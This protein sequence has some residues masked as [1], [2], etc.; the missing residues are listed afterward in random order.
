MVINPEDLQMTQKWCWYTWCWPYLAFS[1]ITLKVCWGI[2]LTS[3]LISL[4]LIGIEPGG[5]EVLRNMC[6]LSKLKYHLKIEPRRRKNVVP[7]NFSYM[8]L[9]FHITSSDKRRKEVISERWLKT[10]P[11]GEGSV[12]FDSRISCL[13]VL[14]SNTWTKGHHHRLA[15]PLQFLTRELRGPSWSTWLKAWRLFSLFFLEH[16]FVVHSIPTFS[17]KSFLCSLPK[18]KKIP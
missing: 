8:Q 7:F 17:L 3:G 6:F 4:F 2:F 12:S 11:L 1:E 13:T 10:W 16:L 18:G 5:K 15:F 14:K 9:R